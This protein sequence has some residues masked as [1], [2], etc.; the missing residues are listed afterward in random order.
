MTESL[1]SYHLPSGRLV[2]AIQWPLSR[3][4]ICSVRANSLYVE[5]PL[6]KD[7]PFY[8]W[9]K[10]S[11]SSWLSQPTYLLSFLY[12]RDWGLIYT[13]RLKWTMRILGSFRSEVCCQAPQHWQFWHLQSL[14]WLGSKYSSK[15]FSKLSAGQFPCCVRLRLRVIKGSDLKFQE[16]LQLSQITYYCVMPMKS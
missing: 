12:R 3:E 7:A 13:K 11:M 1:N 14:I 6:F 2:Q 8:C 10:S 9:Q 16:A 5:P 4:P 15:Q